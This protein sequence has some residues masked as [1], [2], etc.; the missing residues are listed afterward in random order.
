LAIANS[1][2]RP[3]GDNDSTALSL[4]MSVTSRITCAFSGDSVSF[5]LPLPD[6]ARFSSA[7]NGAPTGAATYTVSN[8]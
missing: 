8:G 3:P 4:A 2:T 6:S 5:A 7:V 1:R